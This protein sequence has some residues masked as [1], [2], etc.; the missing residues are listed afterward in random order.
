MTDPTTPAEHPWRRYVAIGDSFTEGMVD[1]DPRHEGRFIGWADRLAAELAG[2]TGGEESGRGAQPGDMVFADIMHEPGARSIMGRKYDQQ[3]EAQA[4]AVLADLAVHPSTARHI[5]TKLA[6]HFVADDPPETLIKRLEANFLKTGGD[7]P[8]LY[9]TLIDSP[10]AWSERPVKFKSPWE[11]TVSALRAV[12]AR[13]MPIPAAPAVTLQQMGQPIWQPG[14]PAGFADTTAEWAGG[15][16]L[17]RRVELAERIAQ[18]T[19][20]RI[21]ARSLSAKL[22]PDMIGKGT[23]DAIARAESPSQGLA[24]LLVSPEFLR[25]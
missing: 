22:L 1:T 5:A 8:S 2:R 14:L 24:L 17:M 10:E 4:R 7:L 16:A 9:R 18:R 3:G 12:G 11:W 15:N 21:D 19:A 6:R 23:Q 13:R 20:N 25:R